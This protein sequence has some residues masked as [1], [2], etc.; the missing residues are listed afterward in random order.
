MTQLISYMGTKRN[1][2]GRVGDLVRE[3][4]PGPLLDV[5]SGM[6]AVGHSVGTSRSIWTNDVQHFAH[7]VANATFCSSNLAPA[8]ESLNDLCACSYEAHR[9]S[10]RHKFAEELAAERLAL[11]LPSC[12]GYNLVFDHSIE[13]ANGLIKG[14]GYGSYDLFMRR[15][16]GSYIGYEQAMDFD[17]LR[18]ALDVLLKNGKLC[19]E[20]HHWSILGLCV[21]LSKCSTTTGHFAQAL[22]P[23]DN[24]F[25]R[26][27][28]QRARS[29]RFEWLRAMEQLAPVGSRQWRASNRAFRSDV[30]G[31]LP[32]L[33]T[34]TRKPS[35]IYADPPY[36]ADQYSRYYHIYETA[37]LYDYPS[38]S[39]R[40][41]Y[42]DGRHASTFS[43]KSTVE[44]SF[45][46]LIRNAAQL[47]ADLIISYPANG[48]LEDS[49][50]R[51]P[52]L[53]RRF[54]K[55]APQ[56]VKIDYSHS[57]MGASKGSQR[58]AVTEILYRVNIK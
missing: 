51:I 17:A 24:T 22:R 42:R 4:R 30:L 38:A 12:S 27:K 41:M 5:F 11:A 34:S 49:E 52:D 29:L 53:L 28:A 7:L 1:L 37:V 50:R 15:F 47:R 46:E 26:F 31:L 36:T 39:G 3:S 2:A 23:K 33:T 19:E 58:Q 8:S 48:L 40:G 6:C 57:T 45:D 10:L 54:Y 32:S 56:I 18:F 20:G 55:R 13:R 14:A 9:A 21:A 43:Q 25:T 35:V 44:R 16:A